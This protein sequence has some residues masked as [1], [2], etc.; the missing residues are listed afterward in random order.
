MVRR[1]MEDRKK[2]D[3]NKLKRKEELM[4]G[5]MKRIIEGIE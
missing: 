3:E 5:L 4:T 2:E 1:M